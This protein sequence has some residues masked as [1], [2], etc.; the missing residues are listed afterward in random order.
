MK[1]RT[2][3]RLLKQHRRRR[4]RLTK[5]E[6]ALLSGI[7]TSGQFT[8]D[9]VL[10]MYAG[11]H[12]FAGVIDAMTD[13]ELD[14]VLEQGKA[15]GLYDTF[16]LLQPSPHGSYIC[17]GC[18]APVFMRGVRPTPPELQFCF[19]CEPPGTSAG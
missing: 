9:A 19:Q 14:Q 10:G 15:N 3:A 12:R 16:R 13:A 18:G 6:E 17:R 7:T 4:V 1:Q 2:R 8:L 11:V 5:D